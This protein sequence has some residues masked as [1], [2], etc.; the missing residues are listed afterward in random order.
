VA[1]GAQL[2]NRPA[3]A[4]GLSDLQQEE[5]VEAA[6]DLGARAFCGQAL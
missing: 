5:H 3:S 4:F 1:T 2:A 6:L